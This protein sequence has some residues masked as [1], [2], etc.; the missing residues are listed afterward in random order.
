MHE[1]SQIL[2]YNIGGQDLF[3]IGLDFGDWINVYV[4]KR[5]ISTD[6]DDWTIR[7]ADGSWAAHWEHTILVQD[8]FPE[9][10]TLSKKCF[11]KI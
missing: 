5:K 1:K 8:H 10:F 2:S 4:G 3:E 9:I 6:H 7:T 11:S